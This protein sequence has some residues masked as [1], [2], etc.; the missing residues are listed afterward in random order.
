MG[1][2]EQKSWPSNFQRGGKFHTSSK[3]PRKN[4][5]LAEMA[6]AMAW[7]LL[8]RPRIEATSMKERK[9]ATPPQMGVGATCSRSAEGRASQGRREASC[10][11]IEVRH[12]PTTKAGNRVVRLLDMQNGTEVV[13]IS[14]VSEW[15]SLNG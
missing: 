9:I 2:R 5:Q 6:K 4:M 14:T 1:V 7:R 10:R 3:K 13:K 8:K 15:D 11:I 12:A